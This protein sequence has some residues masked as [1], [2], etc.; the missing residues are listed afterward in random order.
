MKKRII[1]FLLVLCLIVSLVPAAAAAAPTEAQAYAAM[2]ALK[3]EYYE[4]RPWD[5]NDFYAWNGGIYSGGYGCAGFAFIL[6]DAAFGTLP[7]RRIYNITISDV[8]VGDI[9]RIN[10]DTHSVIVLEVK[11]DH[12]VIAEGNYN[13]SIHWGRTLTAADVAKADY[14]MTRYPE[15]TAP[16]YNIYAE[17]GDH[18]TVTASHTTAAPGTTVTLKVYPDSQYS[19]VGSEVGTGSGVSNPSVTRF[20]MGTYMEYTFE[21][22]AGDIWF[23]FTAEKNQIF[24][25]LR[26]TIPFGGGTASISP[27]IAEAGDEV[28]VTVTPNAGYHFDSYAL[29]SSIGDEAQ[30]SIFSQWQTTP[31]GGSYTFTMPELADGVGTLEVMCFFAIGDAPL[32]SVEVGQTLNI[33]LAAGEKNVYSFT[34]EESGTYVLWYPSQYVK[35]GELIYNSTALFAAD[36]IHY[37]GIEQVHNNADMCYLAFDL[38]GGLTYEL[39]VFNNH[40]EPISYSMLLDKVGPADS[41]QLDMSYYATNTIGGQQYL[42][43]LPGK[44]YQ[45]LEDVTWT[46]DDIRVVS[47][48]KDAQNGGKIIWINGSGVATVTATLP[49]GASASCV[50]MV[51][52]PNPFTDVKAGDYYLAPVLWAAQEK[53]TVGTTASTFS[54]EELC[55][56]AQVVTF[57]WRAFGQPEPTGTVSPFT[58]VKTD[59]WF[60]KAVLWAVE[61]GITIGMGGNRFGAEETCT[62]AQVATFLYRAADEPGHQVADN[63]FIDLAEDWYVSPVLWAYETGITKGDGAANTFNPDGK[64][65][66]AQIVTFLYRFE[67]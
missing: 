12:V 24:Y 65:T 67:H 28:T 30:S 31:A 62:R 25:N 64:C 13:Y 7:A 42:Y 29:N 66:R 11:S 2:V 43:A 61:E 47:V 39:R 41:I 3:D 56:R 50:F 63:P 19:I 38:I 5:N 45:T 51:A 32:P 18:Y 15:E 36:D 27:L 17:N 55:T 16:T 34:P 48:G 58:D 49:N 59:D 21:M 6:S 44:P 8:R 54:P 35:N 10:N 9:L 20:N 1:S 53:I 40:G 4:G 57:L 23:Y 26:A 37:P 46:T 52:I 60:C 14:L 33:S 22:P